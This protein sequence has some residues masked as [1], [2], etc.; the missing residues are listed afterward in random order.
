MAIINSVL[1][2][3]QPSGTISITS[4]TLTNVAAYEYAD[5][6]VPTTAPAYYIEKTKDANGKAGS[7][8][9][10]MD[11]ST[12]TDVGDYVFAYGYYYNTGITG[13][14]DLSSLITVSGTSACWNMFNGCNGI[15]SVDLS[16][17]TSITN[18][19]GC[20]NMF[21]YCT[22]ITSIDLSAL[23]TASGS[24][25]CLT[26]FSGCT[27]ITSVDLSSLTIISGSNGCS[28]M[29]N[30][31]TNLASVNIS[32]LVKL[33]TSNQ[34]QG[35]FQNCTSLTELRF[36]NLA[37]TT[38]NINS[39]FSNTL[40]GVT[41]CT[42]HFPSDWQT[43]MSSWSNIINGMGG[44]NTTVLFDLPAVTTLDLSHITSIPNLGL[45]NFAINNYFPNVTA[46]DLSGVTSIGQSGLANGFRG[47]T[48][49]TSVTFDS[50]NEIE[51]FGL[52]TTFSECTSLTSLSFPALTSTG[53]INTNAFGNMITG[54]TGCTIHF[55]SNL[56]P[57]G[58]STVISSL[59]S[60]PSFG[61]TNTVLAFDLPPTA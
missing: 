18:S 5:V 39:A 6:Q 58:G 40:Q 61:G 30:G 41:G 38:T 1:K 14:I 52:A 24:S 17:L 26:M 37:Y 2:G 35:M 47:C 34:L 33:G 9:Y 59:S 21:Q 4:N 36:N 10:L 49:L 8:S 48:G 19:S 25:A 28:R 57:Q 44:T 13:A 15:T 56:D 60:Y 43:A 3:K 42:V 11:L 29:F 53:S 20:A 23:T 55:P 27:G 45:Q 46:V 54:V 32:H 7:G 31:C 16:S 51:Y 12:F 22:G 50:L